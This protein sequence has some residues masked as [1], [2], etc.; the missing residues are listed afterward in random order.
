MTGEFLSPR[1]IQA[2]G[3][4]GV[5]CLGIFWAITDRLEPLLLA[6]AGSFITG[7]NLLE[8]YLR[9][10]LPPLQEPPSPPPIAPAPP[11]PGE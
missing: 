7:G 3:L 5:V 6:T 1:I 2:V 4:A 9:L 10:R 11:G 8:A